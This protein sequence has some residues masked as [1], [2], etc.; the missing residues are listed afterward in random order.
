M[1]LKVLRVFEPCASEK[2]QGMAGLSI[3]HCWRGSFELLVSVVS[4]LGGCLPQRLAAGP[5]SGQAPPESLPQI[6]QR[7]L[8]R[9]MREAMAQL[10]RWDGGRIVRVKRLQDAARNSGY[11]E[12]MRTQ[13]GAYF[14]VKRMPNE[15]VR[16]GFKEF[17]R[18]HPD[19]G[20]KPWEDIGLV[21][22]LNAIGFPFVCKLLGVFRSDSETLVATTFASGGDLFGWVE[23]ETTPAPGPRREAVMLDLAT[24]IFSGVR[25]LH[26][27]G[28]AHRDLSLENLLLEDVGWGR[29][30]VRIIDFGMAT[31]SRF[32]RREVRGKAS[33]Q[34]P[35]MHSEDSC[36]CFLL[37]SFALGVILFA[38]ASQDYPWMSTK[39]NC[40][41]LFDYVVTFGLRRFLERRKLRNGNGESLSD[42]FSSELT[43]T[44]EAL[45]WSDGELR[46]SLGEACYSSQPAA[47][48]SCTAR[49]S[50]W[51]MAWLK[52]GSGL[53][54]SRRASWI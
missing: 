51:D 50:V 12:L 43:E 20:E 27:L 40:C 10:Q 25:W 5:F 23:R 28:I 21:R 44:I 36:D 14:V 53:Q 30:A 26:E 29:Q 24:Q 42:V 22:H 35:E 54:W 8:E 7:D 37:D 49:S 41:K 19:S 2:I 46:A 34:A 17:A 32:A 47:H 15:W 31:L 3:A 33:Y 18:A 11:V 9:A 45:V 4:G 1:Q 16:L 39:R 38:L 48:A 13:A 6:T 52:R